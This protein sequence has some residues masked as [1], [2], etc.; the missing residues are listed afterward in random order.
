MVTRWGKRF[1]PPCWI[2][3]ATRTLDRTTGQKSK[4]QINGVIM[5][6]FVAGITAMVVGAAITRAALGTGGA[7]KQISISIS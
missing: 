6:K 2:R 3:C 1:C 7:Q 5:K 4:Q